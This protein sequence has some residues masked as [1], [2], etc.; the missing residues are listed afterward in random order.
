MVIPPPLVFPDMTFNM[1]TLSS[2][3]NKTLGVTTQ[4]ILK[5]HGDTECSYAECR[6][7]YCYAVMVNVVRLSVVMQ[8]VVASF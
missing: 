7:F 4:C 6:I 1:T 8:S 5:L 2:L 3:K